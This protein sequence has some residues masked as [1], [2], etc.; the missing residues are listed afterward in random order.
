MADN[1][2]VVKR[3][4]VFTNSGMEGDTRVL[5]STTG[6]YNGKK[7]G[8]EDAQEHT[9][10]IKQL[11]DNVE[12]LQRTTGSSLN[13]WKRVDSGAT[14]GMNP[15]RTIENML[16]MKPGQDVFWF[17]MENVGT[18]GG[19]KPDSLPWY[20]PTEL[21]IR[22]ATVNADLTMTTGERHASI[23]IKPNEDVF[24]HMNE[25]V[26]KVQNNGKKWR[27]KLSKD[28]QRT[29][30]DLILYGAD[31]PVGDGFFSR[32]GNV[33]TVN[34]QNR[35]GQ[36]LA[37]SIF[38]EQ[39][40][41]QMN[42]GL[43]NLQE[44]GT[45][46]EHI[47]DEMNRVFKGSSNFMLG[48]FNIQNYDMPLINDWLRNDIYGR[49]KSPKKQKQF[50]RL[51]NNISTA[52]DVDIRQ[53]T[54][55][56]WKDFGSRIGN[57]QGGG[58]LPKNLKQE[59]I[60]EML[61][62]NTGTAHMGIDDVDTAIEIHNK[63][64]QKEGMMDGFHGNKVDRMTASWDKSPYKK[65]D[66][67]FSVAGI[68]SSQA[69]EHDAVYQL[70][71]KSGKLEAAY[72]MKMNPIF[73]HNEYKI[74]EEYNGVELGGKKQY[75]MMLENMDTG[76]L[77]FIGRESKDEFQNL[78]QQTMLPSETVLGKGLTANEKRRDQARR[79]YA[80]MFSNEGG[81]GRPLL[82]RMLTGLDALEEARD[83]VK[84]GKLQKSEVGKYV[85]NY[86]KD[87]KTTMT[88]G[89]GK[90]GER[91]TRSAT[92]AFFRDLTTMEGRLKA[93]RPLIQ[94]FLGELDRRMPTENK[95][96]NG[97]GHNAALQ[98]FRR[99]MDNEFGRNIG[100]RE[101][102]P[103]Q[104]LFQVEIDGHETAIKLQDK[105]SIE[106]GIR[107]VIHKGHNGAPSIE[108]Q[109]HRLK[110]LVAKARTGGA[111]GLTSK[112]ANEILR[113]ISELKQGDSA[114][115]IINE[116]AGRLD[117]EYRHNQKMGLNTIDVEN[118][119]GM[120]NERKTAIKD[121][122]D[123]SKHSIMDRAIADAK[124]LDKKG[125][126]GGGLLIQD[127]QFKEILKTHNESLNKLRKQIGADA[128]NVGF[129]KAEET[130]NRLVNSFKSDG[131]ETALVY[132]AKE[133]GLVL[134]MAHEDIAKNVFQLQGNEILEHSKVA[135][136]GIPML[137][138]KGNIIM[139]GQQRIG[140]VKAFEE[141][142]GSI[143]LGTAF[144]EATRA[145]GFRANTARNMMKD[146]KILEAEKMLK[147]T[148]RNSVENLSLNNQF[149]SGAD[150]AQY[151]ARKSKASKWL[152][153]SSVDITEYAGQWY[154]QAYA[155]RDSRKKR[156]KMKKD[157]LTF[158]QTLTQEESSRFHREIGGWLRDTK[159]LN[160]NF[161]N[162]KDTHAANGLR[163][164]N[165]ARSLFGFGYYTP[166]ARENIMKS[167]NYAPLASN[168]ME[169][170]ALK[171]TLER[172]VGKSK[173]ERMMNRGFMTDKAI[174]VLGDEVNWL[175]VRAAYMDNKQLTGLM[176]ESGVGNAR[177]ST[178][179][180]MFLIADDVADAFT[181]K[182]EKKARLSGGSKL[183][184]RIE[185]FLSNAV[186][187]GLAEEDGRGNIMM[188][189]D[190]SLLLRKLTDITGRNEEGRITVGTLQSDSVKSL[191]D[192]V[193][194][195]GW[196]AE[197]KS[198]EMETREMMQ[199]TVKMGT[200]SGHRITATIVPRSDFDKMGINA[201]MVVEPDS[202]SK[203]MHG[204]M[205]R[206]QV[207]L[208]V[209][210]IMKQH[211]EM[212]QQKQTVGDMKT[213]RTLDGDMRTLKGLMDKHFNTGEALKV[214]QGRLLIDHEFGIKNNQTIGLENLDAFANE[215]DAKFGTDFNAKDQ[216]IRYGVEG[217]S[218]A[219]VFDW[220]DGVGLR[221]GNRSGLVRYGY[222]EV[223][224]F[225]QRANRVL[226]K[227]N[228]V[229]GWLRN[230]LDEV[231]KAQNSGGDARDKFIRN[232][233]STL[234]DIT[235]EDMKQG[236]VKSGEIVIK[237]N[238]NTF[239]E[240]D[241]QGQRMIRMNDGVTEISSHAFNDIS[242][243]TSREQQLTVGDMKGTILD[244]SSVAKGMQTVGPDGQAID[245]ELDKLLQKNGSMLMELPGEDFSRKYI[246]MIDTKLETVGAGEE[247]MP[248][249]K[250]LQQSQVKMWRLSKQ[251]Q[252]SQ[253][254]D[255]KTKLQREIDNYEKNVA[256]VYS[257][258]RNG[259]IADMRS[260][261]LDMSSRFRIQGI[262]P[263]A[264][265]EM[266]NKYKEG[267]VY[268]SRG[269]AEEMIG[270]AE[271]KIAQAV[272]IEGYDKMNDVELKKKVLDYISSDGLYST[273]NRYPTI[274]ED[275]LQVLKLQ[276]DDDLDPNHRGG[277]FTVGTA[278]RMKAD[279]DGDFF[280]S[281]LSHYKYEKDA[282]GVD[283][284]QIH[285]AYKKIHDVDTPF[286]EEVGKRMYADLEQESSAKG[287]TV[288]TLMRD[289][290]YRDSFRAKWEP[291]V[292]DIY[293]RESSIARLG[294]SD[295]GV[296]DNLR[297]KLSN[298]AS[299]TYNVLD[300]TG[301]F[302]SEELQLKKRKIDDLGRLFSQDSISAKKFSVDALTEDFEKKTGTRVQ[303]GV[304]N[305]ALNEFINQKM[306]SRDQALAM[307]KDG[308]ANPDQV[309]RQNII[310]AGM[311]LGVFKDPDA[312]GMK[313]NIQSG[314]MKF[315]YSINSMLDELQDLH[316][317]SG[318]QQG[319][320]INNRYQMLGVS[321]GDQ[322]PERLSYTARGIGDQAV[323]SPGAMGAAVEGTSM[324]DTLNRTESRFEKSVLSNLNNMQG[325]GSAMESTLERGIIQ[326]TDNMMSSL[327]VGERAGMKF[328]ST[329]NQMGG[330][331]ME[332][333][334]GG[335]GAIVGAGMFGAMWATSALM[336]SGPTPEGLREQTQQQPAAV[337]PL[338]NS[339]P[340]ARVTENGENIN[341]RISA[342]NAK[343]MSEQ[344]I[345]ALVHQEVSAMTQMPM[346]VN[347]NVNDNTQNIDQ[348]WLQGVVAN[349]MNKGFGY[350]G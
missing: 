90:D 240:T 211:D 66:T 118:P 86:N 333:V 83:L 55:V 348:Q 216:K 258:S 34:R 194:I 307:L 6:T 109:K 204:N 173:A 145:L 316:K 181:T 247:A 311:D 196:N 279:Y 253:D 163:S 233:E 68:A 46:A 223:D 263:F 202:T 219:D 65:G 210:E 174:D 261:R 134:A 94:E 75:G 12:V 150:I 271:R 224:M 215:F 212:N 89:K 170:E 269:R 221:E 319:N 264:N 113:S 7:R 120:T 47:A 28:E 347:M 280:S 58:V 329:L 242:P 138:G 63:L 324:F 14:F 189:D 180:G 236:K 218:R 36:A 107:S 183:D 213:K 27:G 146:G 43:M 100:Q 140:R 69:G 172:N 13:T 22:H 72:G 130:L 305:E 38:T 235:D 220:E 198:L 217:L 327:T 299:A 286:L 285:K 272:G 40:I 127:E 20:A 37:G 135:K 110:L 25:L 76:L 250:D 157:H 228:A 294:K 283:A 167:V 31:N 79:T 35:A 91:V 131:F 105:K 193:F 321:E 340:T 164:T 300:K 231:S 115:V 257:S 19:N 306:D 4:G 232:I 273:V 346:N 334:G 208:A 267:T 290:E 179:D 188:K 260:G 160:V 125:W 44:F 186:K 187:D 73:T 98:Q 343:G 262:N 331:M 52:K 176:K 234:L 87:G 249:L 45:E 256:K 71:E 156:D 313:D 301:Q 214:E 84:Q 48:G 230:H 67:L 309:G 292:G 225:E 128:S 314:Q 278:T 192:N 54:N 284:A 251:Y 342:K 241:L 239:H 108:N 339:Q 11:N 197:T 238:G 24:K 62:I 57:L 171:G 3:H 141:Y 195:K 276:I 41:A 106:S 132:D 49:I 80:K 17:D 88:T 8:S 2:D 237:T 143:R 310:Q 168:E 51:M 332:S 153:S 92:D 155:D 103:G 119:T 39:H 345:S 74:M 169:R 1:K 328:S 136:V 122:W 137:D 16:S 185:D 161:H 142:D 133:K 81:G 116:L 175:N 23:L 275:T 336:R 308:L 42:K 341:I 246:R 265:A 60:A 184:S 337:N 207:D 93:E 149:M 222:K 10:L 77:H 229:T 244:M 281:V 199:N 104:G 203:A 304:Q 270:G 121:R 259:S 129:F 322:S 162:V 15:Q 151:D 291:K 112:E 33:T 325:N 21:A 350:S 99:E 53:A 152:R 302:D 124:V 274:A 277:F 61:G 123:T 70:N 9:R 95:T 97:G 85:Q 254:D 182:G 177:M 245:A 30:N 64:V 26:Q 312:P 158:F 205:I 111:S 326:E 144:E 344:D 248:V 349:A 78:L 297:Y 315:D 139:P 295:V 154:G 293:D 32:R 296:L 165:D 317:M 200:T 50:E 288:S 5:H 59:T 318:G 201:D 320:W 101:M 102:A 56:L 117:A 282:Q 190:A 166:M 147:G 96:W 18:F 209:D 206:S 252:E 126:D 323:P 303:T 191:H 298:V 255:T 335:K 148:L 82:E 29:L 268:V 227:G 266:G 226:G 243:L 338:G 114:Q 159:G 178:Y 289:Q 287:V 330:S